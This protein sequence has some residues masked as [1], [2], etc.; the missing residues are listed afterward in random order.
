MSLCESFFVG[1]FLPNEMFKM[2]SFI[3]GE[4]V[5]GLIDGLF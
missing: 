3:D 2:C 5:Y 4:S 1:P